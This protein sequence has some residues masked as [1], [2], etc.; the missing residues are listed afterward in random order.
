MFGLSSFANGVPQTPNNIVNLTYLLP[1]ASAPYQAPATGRQLRIPA[2][3]GGSGSGPRFLLDFLVEEHPELHWARPGS[4][5][6]KAAG[7]NGEV[8]APTVGETAVLTADR[9]AL[10]GN[11]KH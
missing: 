3:T 11:R 9:I 1:S 6:P 8:H 7:G 5:Y 2:W 10:A 4:M